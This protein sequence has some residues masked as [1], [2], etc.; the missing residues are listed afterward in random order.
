MPIQNVRHRILLD[1]A[2][3]AVER[4]L[5]ETHIDPAVFGGGTACRG[6]H[7]VNHRARLYRTGKNRVQEA[8]TQNNSRRSSGRNRPCNESPCNES[9]GRK[10]KRI[11]TTSNKVPIGSHLTVEHPQSGTVIM[12]QQ[13][14]RTQ[15]R[16]HK[17]TLACVVLNPPSQRLPM[18]GRQTR[19]VR[20]R[21]QR[22]KHRIRSSEL[23]TSFRRHVRLR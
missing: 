4:S 7:H 10:E 9:T 21:L 20:E 17:T 5:S 16:S 14:A 15:D 1:G 23:S 3:L 18:S 12:L 22:S 2:L 13:D 8:W 11:L 6:L 19:L